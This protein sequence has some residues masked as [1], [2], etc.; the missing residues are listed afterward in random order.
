[1]SKREPSLQSCFCHVLSEAVRQVTNML[2][3]APHPQW[4]EVDDPLKPTSEFS[5]TGTLHSD[6]WHP[7][8]VNLQPTHLFVAVASVYSCFPQSKGKVQ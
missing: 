3:S 2:Q 8:L 4:D 1:M 5:N 7:A 6:G